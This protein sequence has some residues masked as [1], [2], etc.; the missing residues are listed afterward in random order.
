MKINSKFLTKS[1][2][3]RKFYAKFGA[4]FPNAKFWYNARMYYYYRTG[5]RLDYRH[6]KDINEKLMWLS[7]YW[8]HPLKTQCADKYLVRDY[9]KGLGY[10]C[11]LVPLIGVWDNVNE[12][13]F[14]N[15][16]NQFVLK[17]NH[18]SGFNIIC[19]D[20]SRLNVSDART[21]L[22]SWLST[23]Y[24]KISYE[25][26]Y[27]DI[28]RKII[29]EEL[30]CTVAP[31][32]YQFWCL[33]NEI[34]SVLVC[35]KNYDGTYDAASYSTDW[36]RLYDRINEE[37]NIVDF[38]KPICWNELIQVAKDLSKPFPFVRAD[39]YVVDDRIYFAELTFTPAANILQA[40]KE[41]FLIRLGKKLN[42]PKKY[43]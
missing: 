25:V 30:L 42:L 35:R 37:Q 31:I 28:P 21:K 34:D 36:K 10:E 1:Y 23:D 19:L 29:C 13:N 16:P 22:N 18:G 41:A 11:I 4:I 9:I 39:F 2:Y 6:P 24:S 7:R 5:K 17:C 3:E 38:Q 43:K 12:I 8:Q 32:E 20:K 14:S 26:H 15:L 40:Y 27:H 33:N